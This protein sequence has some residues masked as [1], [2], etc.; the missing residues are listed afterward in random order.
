MENSI[1]D[2]GRGW[3]YDEYQRE[4]S[5]HSEYYARENSPPKQ[6][7]GRR[8][9]PKAE[10][11]RS[12][13]SKPPKAATTKHARKGPVQ[14]SIRDGVVKS[15]KKKKEKKPVSKEIKITAIRVKKNEESTAGKKAALIQEIGGSPAVLSQ[16]EINAQQNQQH[17]EHQQ[18]VQRLQLQQQQMGLIAAGLRNVPAREGNHH[19]IGESDLEKIT[20]KSRKKKDRRQDYDSEDSRTSTVSDGDKSRDAYRNSRRKQMKRRSVSRRRTVSSSDDE[21]DP[22]RHRSH[23]YRRAAS[24]RSDDHSHSPRHKSSSHRRAESFREDRHII[25]FTRRQ[26]YSFDSYDNHSPRRSRRKKSKKA[27]GKSVPDKRRHTERSMRKKRWDLDEFEHKDDVPWLEDACG[28]LRVSAS[29][30]IGDNPCASFDSEDYKSDS[31]RHFKND[32]GSE[33]TAKTLLALAAGG[34]LCL[35]CG[36]C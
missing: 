16:Q 12:H 31:T 8:P 11:G 14:Y 20:T 33:N 30:C 29:Q 27:R 17:M 36:P 15:D 28:D 6:Y 26:T 22:P 35:L 24:F 4:M 1:L 9:P 34:T 10:Y 19:E 21:S 13:A 25:P 18:L 2:S 23:S 3:D 7:Y 5:E 32:R